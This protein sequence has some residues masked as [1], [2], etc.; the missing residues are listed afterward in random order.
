M[1]SIETTVETDPLAAVPLTGPVPGELTS[2]LCIGLVCEDHRSTVPIRAQRFGWEKR[3]RR[4]LPKSAD[5]PLPC[6]RCCSKSLGCVFKNGTRSRRRF[7]DIAVEVDRHRRNV[8]LDEAPIQAHRVLVN[9]DKPRHATRSV[10]RRPRR[11]ERQRRRDHLSTRGKTG[12][13]D[14]RE[15]ISA[16]VADHDRA[17]VEVLGQLVLQ[18]AHFGTANEGPRQNHI[19]DRQADLAL[20]LG[21]CNSQI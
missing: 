17:S 21:V 3:K 7:L 2:K 4:C 15:C 19:L 16:G 13:K 10:D 18:Q 11:A 1:E 12:S 14:N 8:L 5:L 20:H 6:A 9:I